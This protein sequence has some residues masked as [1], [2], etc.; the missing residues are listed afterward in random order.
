MWS[1]DN[2]WVRRTVE[3]DAFMLDQ[4][5][6]IIENEVLDMAERH[7]KASIAFQSEV[8][9]RLVK[10][11]PQSLTNADLIRWWEIA[12][13]VER[14][15]RGEPTERVSTEQTGTVTI[16][17]QIAAMSDEELKSEIERYKHTG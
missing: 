12:V 13:K 6:R 10:F 8:I 1:S 17:Q 2:D 11:D 5:R 9:K 15:A 16:T 14:L 3:Y 4:R 7:A